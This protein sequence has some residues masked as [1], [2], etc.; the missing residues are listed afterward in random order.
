MLRRGASRASPCRRQRLYKLSSL[1]RPVPLD[2]LL[3]RVAG[4]FI[5]QFRKHRQRKTGGRVV[6]AVGD[7]RFWIRK[8]A[9]GI[10]RLLVDCDRVVQ[11]DVDPGL[12]Q[13][14][15]QAVALRMG[16]HIEVVHVT[17]SRGFIRERET[18]SP[19]TL[20]VARGNLAPAV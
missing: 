9:P 6:F 3:D 18:R 2:A 15:L 13:E 11:F 10:A 5:R 12:E 7:M 8:L 17:I 20:G 4:L 16:N 1:L 19:K 14:G